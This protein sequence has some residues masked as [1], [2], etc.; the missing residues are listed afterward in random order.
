MMARWDSHAILTYV[1]DAPLI[2]IPREYLK[3]MKVV[4][5]SGEDGV[6]KQFKDKVTKD[7]KSLQK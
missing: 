6:V 1:K 2:T 4:A 3:G 5:V 7:L